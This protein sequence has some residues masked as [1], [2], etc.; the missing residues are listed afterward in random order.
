MG[1]KMVYI[2]NG[3]LSFKAYYC[4][5]STDGNLTC[6]SNSAMTFSSDNQG[7]IINPLT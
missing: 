2:F 6:T 1:S 4:N 3:F 7:N 5:P